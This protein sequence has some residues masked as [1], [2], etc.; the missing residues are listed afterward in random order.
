[1]QALGPYFKVALEAA[2]GIAGARFYAELSAVLYA[3]P[4]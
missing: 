4:A 2:Q 1:L 3:R